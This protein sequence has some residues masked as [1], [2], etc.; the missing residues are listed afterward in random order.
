MIDQAKRRDRSAIVREL[1]L[2]GA[3]FTGSA[4]K[5]PYHEDHSPS[6]SIYQ[7]DDGAWWYKCHS[8]NVCGDVYN[9]ESKRTNQ[10]LK[11]ILAN[12]KQRE[13]PEVCN[14]PG[15]N[16]SKTP[17]V[18]KGND[19]LN[20]YCN[21]IGWAVANHFL[22]EDQDRQPFMLVVRL[23]KPGEKSFRQFRKVESG[24]MPEAPPKP[25][26]LYKLPDLTEDYQI[27]VCE[28]EKAVEALWGVGIVATTSPCGARKAK[29]TDW[30]A[31]A[32][33]PVVLWPDN[34]DVGI[35]HMDGVEIEL[36]KL[37]PQPKVRR[38]NPADMNLIDA[39]G[40]DVEMP[41]KGDAADWVEC[42]TTTG[43][44]DNNMA[45]ETLKNLFNKAPE[46][47]LSK[48]TEI[49][50]SERKPILVYLDTVEPEEVEWLWE[51]RIPLNGISMISGDPDLG[52]TF[53][54]LSIAA[55]LS[56]GKPLPDDKGNYREPA[57]VIILTAEDSLSQTIR[58][59]L[60]AMEADC[61]QI[62]VLQGTQKKDEKGNVKEREFDLIADIQHLRSAIQQV[63][64]CIMVMIDPISSYMG[65]VDTHKNS[66]VRSAL[67]PLKTLAE[68]MDVSIIC[69]NHLSKGG[70]SN[71]KYRSIGSIAFT[72]LP[73]ATW[74]IVEDLD[75]EGR[76]LMLPVKN[77]LSPVKNNGIAYRIID[78][79]LQWDP[80]PVNMSAQDYLKESFD[81]PGPEPLAR[82]EAEEFL[83]ELLA[84]GPVK[85]SD[86]YADAKQAGIS[87]STINRAKTGMGIKPYK[88]SYEEGW[89]WSLPEGA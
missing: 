26:K 61:S 47:I 16:A 3:T 40:H 89:Y 57:G 17:I 44:L 29:H 2:A 75:N 88:K 59:R 62:A 10:P 68:E 65:G 56:I 86:V 24:W 20:D 18:L 38:I 32:G 73:R 7:G 74:S 1:E 67:K 48:P 81:G 43:N 39:D 34:D 77:N 82:Q 45:A 42:F 9:L 55:Y 87:K 15:A 78:N 31:L 35:D 30:S 5:C 46:V 14:P 50:D 27:V 85:S 21:R 8:C 51:N 60:D 37:T 79:A 12:Q 72:A 66:D 49:D 41:E 11:K 63:D 58:P 80:E 6:G 54:V 71:A 84:D 52:K 23:E 25:W 76:C 22:Y 36:A 69:I 33:K 28:G 13:T 53:A 70:S 83:Y 4:V 64:N 19:E